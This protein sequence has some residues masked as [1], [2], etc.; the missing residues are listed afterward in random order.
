[1]DRKL[2]PVNVT[3]YRRFAAYFL[4]YTGIQRKQTQDCIVMSWLGGFGTT[5]EYAA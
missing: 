2:R 3:V 4:L 1:M 5:G